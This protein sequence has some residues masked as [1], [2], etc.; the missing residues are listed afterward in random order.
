MIYFMDNI[1][2]L[3][4]QHFFDELVELTTCNPRSYFNILKSQFSKKYRKSFC[5]LF[6]WI[7]EQTSNHLSLKGHGISTMV[8]WILNGIID[9]PRCNLCGKLIGQHSKIQLNGKYPAYCHACIRKIC[10]QKSK[11]TAKNKATNDPQY[12]ERIVQKRKYTN[13]ILHDNPNWNNSK[14]NAQTCLDKYGVDNIRKTEECK[15]KIKQTKKKK[16]GNENYVNVKLHQQTCLS[17][18]GVVSAMQV[19]EIRAKARTKYEFD[20]FTFDSKHELCYYIW[21][22]DHHVCFVFKPNASFSYVVDGKQHFYMPDFIVDGQYVEIKGD[23]FF[24][25]DGTMQNPYDHSLD[26]LYEAKRQCMLTNGV[27]I[28]KQSECDKYVNYVIETYGNYYWKKFK[29]NAKCTQA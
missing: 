2:R 26:Y 17:R 23:H 15:K 5:Y 29:L 3:K 4:N 7:C 10:G 20:N 13:A 12:Y 28:I 6:D 21:L 9:F 27:K 11:Q 19:P 1:Y 25:D 16:Y 8:Y 22:R 24:K 18:Y 14:K